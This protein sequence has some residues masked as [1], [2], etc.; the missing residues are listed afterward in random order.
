ME[1]VEPTVID[2][3]SPR[4]LRN[5]C[6]LFTTGVAVVTHRE[7]ETVFGMTVNSFTSVSLEPPLVLICL[8]Q[9]S[10]LLGRLV[11]EHTL[12]LSFLTEQQESHSR[13]FAS[14]SGG[15]EPSYFQADLPFLRDAAGGLRCRVEQ[16]LPAGDHTI[17]LL[18]VTGVWTHPQRQGSLLYHRGRYATAPG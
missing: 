3:F 7:G 12:A 8:A 11:V 15:V 5:T 14:Q 13:Y 6:G 10:N 18:R 9:S 16:L 4:E 1:G 2:E 17:V